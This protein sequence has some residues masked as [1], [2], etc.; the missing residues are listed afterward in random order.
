MAGRVRP[1]LLA[2]SFIGAAVLG[3]AAPAFAQ[4]ALHAVQDGYHQEGAAQAS[5]LSIRV[6]AALPDS[7][8]LLLPDS[9]ACGTACPG[10]ALSFSITNTSE[11]PL[12]VVGVTQT[13]GAKITSSKAAC[14]PYAHFVAPD[15]T[16]RPWPLIPPHATLQ[17][18][19]SDAFQLG[20]GLIHL[21]ADTPN[22]CQGALFTV[23][24]TVAAE[25]AG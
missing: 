3:A 17:V 8:V 14:A 2:L 10:G 20:L 4:S 5:R 7:R 25:P 16:A 18:S 23:P 21:A 13:D 19:G 9:S 15:L 1:I 12:R 22:D 6:E 11:V 24:L